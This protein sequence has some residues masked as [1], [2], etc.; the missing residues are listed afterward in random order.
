MIMN[1]LNLLPSPSFADE[2]ESYQIFKEWMARR[3]AKKALWLKRRYNNI[4]LSRKVR[5][6]QFDRIVKK[7]RE[8]DQPKKLVL[9]N[10]E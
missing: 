4:S 10:L 5:Q 1:Y 7:L 9:L 2:P 8:E 6:K 3:K